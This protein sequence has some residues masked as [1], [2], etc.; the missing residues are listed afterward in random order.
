MAALKS[1]PASAMNDLVALAV[2]A[3]I[4]FGLGIA[5]WRFR[6]RLPLAAVAVVDWAMSIIAALGLTIVVVTALELFL[7]S[8]PRFSLVAMYAVLYILVAEAIRSV[9]RQTSALVPGRDDEPDL[10]FPG[11]LP[12]AGPIGHTGHSTEPHLHFH[13]QDSADLFRGMGLPVRF[14]ASAR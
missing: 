14:L 6:A 8:L 12:I 11:L 4:A 2:I 10:E 13:L 5:R 3:V 9:Q 1:R 7:P